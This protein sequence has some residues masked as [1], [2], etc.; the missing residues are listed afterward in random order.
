MQSEILWQQHMASC[1]IGGGFCMYN[2]S[3]MD[4]NIRVGERG[5][6]LLQGAYL[7]RSVCQG[8]V[9]TMNLGKCVLIALMLQTSCPSVL[10]F[11]DQTFPLRYE[12]FSIIQIARMYD[13]HL[14]HLLC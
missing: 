7:C 5:F 1:R 14:T 12:E 3:Y 2:F 8:S 10:R 6:V 11:C 13:P 9:H 4:V